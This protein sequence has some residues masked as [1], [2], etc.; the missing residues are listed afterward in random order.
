MT[1]D[2]LN[3]PYNKISLQHQF[4]ITLYKN[5]K[6]LG[7]NFDKIKIFTIVRNPYDRIISDLFFHKLIT[8]YD[9]DE[10]VY[11][12]IK[13][14]YLNKN[15]LDNHNVP[16]YKFITDENG[17]LIPNIKIFNT[18]TLNTSNNKLNKFLGFNIDIK[19]QNVNKDYG[20]YLNNKSIALINKFYK[21][22]FELFKYI[23]IE[24]KDFVLFKY[25]N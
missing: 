18:E 20:K 13:N 2:L 24:S 12:I 15:N 22:D 16:Q 17:N 1:N 19:K 7:I 23:M 6:K 5:R 25:V 14:N 8:K 21:K 9:S 10:E 3:P 11:H 4:Y